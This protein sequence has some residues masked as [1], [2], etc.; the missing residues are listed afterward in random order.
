MNIVKISNVT[1]RYKKQ[2]VLKN[3]FTEFEANKIHGIVG[4][5]GSGKTVLLKL[6]SGLAKPNSGKITVDDKVIGKDIEHPHD[7]GMIIETPGFLSYQSGL[8][9]LT[10]LASFNNKISKQDI[11]DVIRKVGLNPRSKKHVG[12]Y[13]LGMRQRLGIAQAIMEKPKL[14]LLDEPFN[15]LDKESI[16]EMRNILLELKDNGT[17]ILIATHVKEDVDILC[18]SVYKIEN[19]NIKRTY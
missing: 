16:N 17:T 1:K 19:G 2:D 15:G 5:N 6:I 8:K 18:D 3:V 7:M 4:R 10:Y 12:K 14:L 9:N 11:I 13:S